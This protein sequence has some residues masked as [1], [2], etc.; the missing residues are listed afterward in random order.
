MSDEPAPHAAPPTDAERDPFDRPYPLSD[1]FREHPALAVTSAY[2]A[3]SIVGCLFSFAFYREFGVNFFN[4]ADISDLLMAV[5]REPMTFLLGLGAA[6]VAYLFRAYYRWE[7]RFFQRHPP[8]RWYARLY[9]RL[10]RP[11]YHSPWSDVVALVA[12][13]LL[14]VTL[15]GE[16]KADQVRAERRGDRVLV[17]ADGWQQQTTLLGATARYLLVWDGQAARVSAIP[18]ESVRRVVLLGAPQGAGTDEAPAAPGLP[19]GAGESAPA[20]ASP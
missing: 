1:L 7:W 5:L 16:Y 4:F 12:Y 17:E 18:A 13:T 20:Q 6:L 14:F 3:A 11:N 2:V 10:S 15:Y 19:D 9:Y 8:R